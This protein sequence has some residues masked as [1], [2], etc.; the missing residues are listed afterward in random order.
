MIFFLTALNLASSYF[1]CQ[2]AVVRDGKGFS[3]LN[4]CDEGLQRLV[5]FKEFEDEWTFVTDYEAGIEEFAFRVLVQVDRCE[6]DLLDVDSD[7]HTW[8]A[9]CF[10]SGR[11]LE[12]QVANGRFVVDVEN[13]EEK[14][15]W[16]RPVFNRETKFAS[17]LQSKPEV[18]CVELEGDKS[19]RFFPVE[20]DEGGGKVEFDK[21]EKGNFVLDA[22]RK[23]VSR[24]DGKIRER[25]KGSP[26]CRCENL[27]EIDP[28]GEFYW[29][30][31]LKDE[32]PV[33]F[34]QAQDGFYFID[35]DTGT[36][37]YNH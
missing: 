13:G 14:F 32:L 19:G 29:I 22:G 37:V 2:D 17:F 11:R 6:G 18:Q 35:P 7:G 34:V 21:D 9:W 10:E 27:F 30:I 12:F 16:R 25:V 8:P 1:L 20:Y 5:F 15:A 24:A 28:S 36:R 4:Y 31:L 23:R 3:W 33:V 26:L